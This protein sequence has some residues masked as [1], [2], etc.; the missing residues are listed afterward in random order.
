MACYPHKKTFFFFKRIPQGTINACFLT[1]ATVTILGR[2]PVIFTLTF[3]DL[4]L[5]KECCHP[6]FIPI[7]RAVQ[8]LM[9]VTSSK[10]NT[11]KCVSLLWQIAIS[12]EV[13]GSSHHILLELHMC[14]CDNAKTH[15]HG[16]V[17][18]IPGI[19]GTNET[20]SWHKFNTDFCSFVVGLLKVQCG[21]LWIVI[22]EIHTL[23]T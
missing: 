21:G 19:L 16:L 3:L 10:T 20:L 1:W 4:G 7:W 2:F 11:Q 13:K 15:D 22:A 17:R 9:T 6:C 12:G 23:C 14:Q 8:R 5:V 18:K